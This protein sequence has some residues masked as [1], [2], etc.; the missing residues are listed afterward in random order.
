[1]LA[2]IDV[3]FGGRFFVAPQDAALGRRTSFTLRSD[4]MSLIEK[5]LVDNSVC[6]LLSTVILCVNHGPWKS[7]LLLI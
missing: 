7:M 4:K 5:S 3:D 6:S 2:S 1:M